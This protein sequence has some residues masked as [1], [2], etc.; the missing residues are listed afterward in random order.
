MLQ[1]I[2]KQLEEA[3]NSSVIK[4]YEKIGEPKP[5]FGVMRGDINKLAKKYKGNSDVALELWQTKNLDAMLLATQLLDPKKLSYEQSMKLI[6]EELSQTVLTPLIEKVICNTKDA[7][8]IEEELLAST[9]L[10]KQSLAWRLKVKYFGSKKS[11]KEEIDTTLEIIKGQL[12][13][14]EELV[15][16]AMNYCLVTIAVSYESYREYCVN[17]G[18]ELAVYKDQKVAKGCTSAY[19]PAWIAAVV[20]NKKL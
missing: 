14:Q 13:K 20:K 18:E 9:S 8:R 2:L 5:Y 16:W 11:T 1:E 17:L 19:A 12:A 3:A 6:D 10:V 7:R 15:R 4:R